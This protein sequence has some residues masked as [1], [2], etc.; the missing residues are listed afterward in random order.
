MDA[1]KI[2]Q[3]RLNPNLVGEPGFEEGETVGVAGGR[4]GGQTFPVVIGPM[5]GQ[6]PMDFYDPEALERDRQF[7][8]DTDAQ[9]QREADRWHGSDAYDLASAGSSIK[10][11]KPRQSQAE[12][13]K[14]LQRRRREAAGERR[15]A[16]DTSTGNYELDRDLGGSEGY[17][18]DVTDMANYYRDGGRLPR[19]GE[20][21]FDQEGDLLAWDERNPGNYH[22]NKAQIRHR[23]R[24]L[25]DPSVHSQQ[26]TD[27][28]TPEQQR[29]WADFL[30]EDASLATR[31]RMGVAPPVRI[32]GKSWRER[33]KDGD[34]TDEQAQVY[35]NAEARQAQ[36]EILKRY[37][38]SMSNETADRLA[39][40][41]DAVQSGDPDAVA[42]G[43]EAIRQIRQQ[44]YRNNL[45]DRSRNY[46]DMLQNRRIVGMLNNPHEREGFILRTMQTGTPQERSALMA[47]LGNDEAYAAEM[48]S[49]MPAGGDGKSPDETDAQ[50]MRRQ[51]NEVKN[52]LLEGNVDAAYQTLR[53]QYQTM[54]PDA[55]PEQ[56]QQMAN[57]A[58]EDM[59]LSMTYGTQAPGMNYRQDLRIVTRMRREAQAGWESFLSFAA[60]AGMTYD[61]AAAEYRLLTGQ[62][63]PS[64]NSGVRLPGMPS[65][66]AW[67]GANG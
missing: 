29:E 38:N 44:G 17:T 24:L 35:I 45:L 57:D 61:Q 39:S 66:Q 59:M 51:Y 22:E 47:L 12:I 13:L 53:V 27:L 67:G 42:D 1:T 21:A 19:P 14:D 16:G 7:K 60:R 54:Y 28:G 5:T 15:E 37:G 48:A 64:A 30:Q 63:P 23:R 36:R 34:I 52:M 25:R 49:M 40:A 2:R 33:H 55:P 43:L 56:H 11:M 18:E 20:E 41:V 65:P 32:G 31:Q 3:L 58:L 10:H 4:D 6:Q 50:V 9:M 8:R 26:D 46:D 62:D